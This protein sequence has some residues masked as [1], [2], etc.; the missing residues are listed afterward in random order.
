MINPTY[1]GGG[2][3]DDNNNNDNNN[4]NKQASSMRS[5]TSIAPR[6]SGNPFP[7]LTLIKINKI[8]VRVIY[9]YICIYSVYTYIYIYN[10]YIIYTY[11]WHVCL[12][13]YNLDKRGFRKSEKRTAAKHVPRA[14]GRGK[15]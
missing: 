10:I 4:D 2:R 9:I 6:D 7:S 12:G 15:G 13:S 8:N 3:R 14:K 5:G 11:K 1:G